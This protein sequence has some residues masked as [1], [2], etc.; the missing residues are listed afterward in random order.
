MNLSE[1]AHLTAVCDVCHVQSYFGEYVHI[2]VIGFSIFL[3]NIS[4]SLRDTKVRKPLLFVQRYVKA[5]SLSSH[6]LE[7]N[8][9]YRIES[10]E[11]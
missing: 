11:I 9:N 5:I 4:T 1:F 7:N 3:W 8:Q 2:F 6:I 10:Q